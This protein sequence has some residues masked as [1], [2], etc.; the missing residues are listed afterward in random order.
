M[1]TDK[2][3]SDE[4]E[5]KIKDSSEKRID[6]EVVRTRSGRIPLYK[7]KRVRIECEPGY[8]YRQIKDVDDRIERFKIAGY[9]IVSAKVQ[10]NGRNAQDASQMGK[11]G[12]QSVGGGIV[13]Y[14]MRLPQEWREDDRR[15]KLVKTDRIMSQIKH[16]FSAERP[17]KNIRGNVS[18]DVTDKK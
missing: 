2:M 15:E 10:K 1:T 12:A 9:E 11:V 7:Q 17:I 13:G 4:K 16:G 5:N 3:T 8:Y 18:I 6:E 14:Y